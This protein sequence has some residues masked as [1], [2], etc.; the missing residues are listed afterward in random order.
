MIEKKMVKIYIMG[1]EYEVPAS[2]TIMKAMEYSC[3]KFIR[4][5]GCR[6]GVCGACATVYRL[7]DSYKINVGLA[8]QT[9]IE[10][11]MYLTQIPFYPANRAVYDINK[12]DPVVEDI[13]KRYPE[14]AR[15]LCCNTCKKACPQDLEA[16]EF[17][18]AALR[19]DIEKAAKLSFECIM[20]GL[21]ASRC[22]AEIVHYNVAVL[23]RRLYAKYL[24]PKAEHL[25]KRVKEIEEGQF[26][27]EL[28]RYE[29]IDIE[30]LKEL[31][32]KRDIEP[33]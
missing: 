27:E 32:D 16:M 4:G 8:C 17:I 20:C 12:I 11:N 21:C 26:D 3:Y 25:K 23:C 22:P 18:Q 33:V 1:K 7:P 9:V 24:V 14:I 15:C 19:G 13:L 29:E 31:Y 28:N 6:G 5:S 30:K 2:L 10:P